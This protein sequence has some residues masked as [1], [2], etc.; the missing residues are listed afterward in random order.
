MPNDNK[1]DVKLSGVVVKPFKV[2]LGKAKTQKVKV[3]EYKKGDTYETGKANQKFFDS[4]V[5]KG[6]IKKTEK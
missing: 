6:R 4:L 2:S 3:A 5:E 1:T